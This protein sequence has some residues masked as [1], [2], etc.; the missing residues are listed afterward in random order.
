M[1]FR[2]REGD[3]GEGRLRRGGR[4]TEK[5]GEG[6]QRIVKVTIERAKS[7]NIINSQSKGPVER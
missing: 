5:K 6:D 3:C 2:Q 4:K 7:T 1:L